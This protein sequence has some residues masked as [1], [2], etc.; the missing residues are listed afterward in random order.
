MQN[1][2]ASLEQDSGSSDAV[3]KIMFKAVTSETPSL[4]LAGTDMYNAFS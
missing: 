3:A 1:A 4:Y 2:A